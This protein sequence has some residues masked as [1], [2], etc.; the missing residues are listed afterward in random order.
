MVHAYISMEASLTS[1]EESALPFCGLKT[2]RRYGISTTLIAK[3]F[4]IAAK[5]SSFL[6]VFQVEYPFLQFA[7]CA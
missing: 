2:L 1:P 4:K 5:Y 3:A 6:K 7:D